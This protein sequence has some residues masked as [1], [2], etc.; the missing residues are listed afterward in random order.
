MTKHLITLLVV[1]SMTSCA[2]FYDGGNTMLAKMKFRGQYTDEM[3]ENVR[4]MPK[5]SIVPQKIT[6]PASIFYEDNTTINPFEVFD[7]I[8][9]VKLETTSESVI[10]DIDRC[11]IVK[12]TIYVLDRL[13]SKSIKL[14]TMDGKYVRSIGERGNGPGEYTQATDMFVND[15]LVLIFDQ[16]QNKLIHYTHDGRL[17]KDMNVPFFATQVAMLNNGKYLFVG[18]GL[19]NYHLDII[20]YNIWICDTNKIIESK[21]FY[22][23]PLQGGLF[24]FDGMKRSSEGEY[25]YTEIT[26]D[27]VYRVNENGTLSHMFLLDFEKGKLD[28]E[29][30]KNEK[31]YLRREWENIV[32][33]HSVYV[34]GKYVYIDAFAS[35][36]AYVVYDREKR[37]YVAKYSSFKTEDSDVTYFYR[38]I[39]AYRD[40]MVVWGA[41]SSV[42]EQIDKGEEKKY[43]RDRLFQMYKGVETDDNPML[44]FLKLKK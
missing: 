17:L 4:L 33:V 8:G 42:Y 39:M 28:L 34:V 31:K 44:F 9:V 35:K 6:I 3:H 7:S 16:N 14:F 29:R 37:E 32:K 40:C 10:G 21:G 11:Y 43:E 13:L 24:S 41:P 38:P 30:Y 27:T 36:I 2:E 20:N 26:S 23:Y 18:S 1:T 22:C 15:S 12:D 25:Y 19:Q 5:D